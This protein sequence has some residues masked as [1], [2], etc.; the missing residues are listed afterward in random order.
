MGWGLSIDQSAEGHVFC[1]EADFKTGPDDYEG[2]PPHSFQTIAEGVESFH[3]EIDFARDEMGLDAARAQC[4][5]AFAD[6]KRMYRR[7]SDEEK[8]E[9]H[10]SYV[11][12]LRD[13]L[14]TCVVD[15]KRQKDKEALIEFFNVQ[16]GPALGKLEAD[17]ARL[18]NE[19]AKKRKE[20]N[21]KR[22]PLTA[23]ESELAAITA[24][25]L[26]KKEIQALIKQ[27]TDWSASRD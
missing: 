10:R 2:Y 18:E 23:L 19:L 15:R 16:Y 5:E 25:A 12:D 1:S 26:R 17:I 21:E 6:A 11:K 8:L 14:K 22:E 13:E 27:E 20:Y 3:S 9:L 4:W 24:P 7:L